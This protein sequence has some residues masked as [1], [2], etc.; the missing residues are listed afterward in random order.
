M[1]I[2]R[3]R[4]TMKTAY[5]FDDLKP[6][7]GTVVSAFRRRKDLF[8]FV[9]MMPQMGSIKLWKIRGYITEDDGGPDGLKI[10]VASAERISKSEVK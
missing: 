9:Q 2:H 5:R 4:T 7:T 10:K 6:V 1:G 3:K 8:E